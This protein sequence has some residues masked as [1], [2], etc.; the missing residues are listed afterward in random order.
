MRLISNVVTTTRRIAPFVTIAVFGIANA[1]VAG[2]YDDSG[3]TA[4][5]GEAGLR[6]DVT[7]PNRIIG[8]IVGSLSMLFGSIFLVLVMYGGIIWMTAQGNEEKIKK[9]KSVIT[10]AVVGLVLVFSSYAIANVVI[11]ALSS[12]TSTAPAP[13]PGP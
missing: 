4:T 9:A 6:T 10:S 2:I 8:G 7:N 11:Q 5:A 12:A 3:L 13:E 1:A